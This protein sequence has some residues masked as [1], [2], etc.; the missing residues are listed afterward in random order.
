MNNLTTSESTTKDTLPGLGASTQEIRGTNRDPAVDES[1]D[2]TSTLT[3]ALCK[4]CQNMFETPCELRWAPWKDIIYTEMLPHHSSPESFLSSV[5][6]QC[7]ICAALWRDF[8]REAMPLSPTSPF[9]RYIFADDGVLVWIKF[10]KRYA[11]AKAHLIPIPTHSSSVSQDSRSTQGLISDTSTGA[12]EVISLAKNWLQNCLEHHA[13]CAKADTS[14][15]PRR[16][17]HIDKG[18]IQLQDTRVRRPHDAYVTLSHCWGGAKASE[19]SILTASNLEEYLGA[20]DLDS[21]PKTF[22]D[23]IDITARLDYKYLWIDSLCILQSGTGSKQDWLDHTMEMRH[24]YTNCLLNIS[25]DAAHSPLDGCYSSRAP[26]LTAASCTMWQGTPYQLYMDEFCGTHALRCSKLSSRAWVVQERLFS[27]RVLHMGA[28]QIFWECS[29]LPLACECRPDGVSAEIATYSGCDFP[30]SPKVHTNDTS[31]LH[32]AGR[33]LW[34]GIINHYTSSDLTYPDKDK[35]VAL[36]GVAQIASMFFKDDYRAGFFRSD[37]LWDLAWWITAKNLESGRSCRP[38]GA[39]RAPSWSW[40]SIDGPVMFPQDA[41]Q[42]LMVSLCSVETTPLNAANPWGA[43]SSGTLTLRG[44]LLQ[45][46]SETQ[47]SN[48]R[49]WDP[50]AV[51]WQ[52][53]DID[54]TYDSSFQ[55]YMDEKDYAFPEASEARVSL[56]PLMYTAGSRTQAIPS[57]AQGLLLLRKMG[58]KNYTRIG[59]FLVHNWKAQ[60]LQVTDRSNTIEIR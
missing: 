43:V 11:L 18:R 26:I 7:R 5:G 58:E 49:R 53:D 32:E 42:C 21:L 40:A 25:A 9:S 45:V 16:L 52:F 29:R 1:W 47:N 48:Q 8:A 13:T 57:S 35:L 4:T 34:L 22:A 56:L 30:F 24:V 10:E 51:L 37:L 41:E 20:I 44:L 19:S 33:K 38:E 27:P 39:Y 54:H 14:W 60:L 3:P 28:D 23:A 50:S 15:Y 6:Q 31:A 55:V 12:E 36:S 46:T 2:E 17:L 59:T